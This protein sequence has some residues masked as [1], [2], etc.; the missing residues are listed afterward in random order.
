[1]LSTRDIIFELIAA[2]GEKGRWAERNVKYSGK[3]PRG[4]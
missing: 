2:G 3:K 4:V 1:L